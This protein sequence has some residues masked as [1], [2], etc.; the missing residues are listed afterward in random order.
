MTLKLI[1]VNIDEK[2]VVLA[3][4]LRKK[5]ASGRLYKSAN[6][7][8][9]SKVKTEQQHLFVL[10]QWKRTKNKRQIFK[11]RTICFKKSVC[12]MMES[13]YFDFKE[14]L[15]DTINKFTLDF[16]NK[17]YIKY[18][19]YQINFSPKNDLLLFD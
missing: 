14:T 1:D 18:R 6:F 8:K 13:I 2:V 10:A 9:I 17:R 4:C 5:D 11:A 16:S 15:L 3:E 7:H 12:W 19:V